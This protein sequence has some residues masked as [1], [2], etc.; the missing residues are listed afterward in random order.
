MLRLM[1]KN[2][3][4][5]LF[6][7]L[8]WIP[9][10]IMA[11]VLPGRPLDSGMVFFEGGWIIIILLGSTI[12]C[13]QSEGKTKGYDFLKTLPI[14]DSQIVRAKFFLVFLTACFVYMY[15]RIIYLFVSIPPDVLVMARIYIPLCVF[16][17]L[18]L[19]AL[20][21]ILVFK[22]GLSRAIK[23][24]WIMFFGIIVLTIVFI[25]AVLI[26]SDIDARKIETFINSI[27]FVIWMALG[28]GIL[29]V[30]FMLMSFAIK[31]KKRNRGLD[32]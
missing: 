1:Q 21:Y 17:G 27:P 15:L 9:I 16:V 28:A 7:A 31:V 2:S 11:I 30:Y 23:I 32:K 20:L 29:A 10:F 26:K 5:F 13:E 22:I 12:T 18:L 19:A 6:Y 24:G 25:E 8:V 3:F 14:K 4:Y